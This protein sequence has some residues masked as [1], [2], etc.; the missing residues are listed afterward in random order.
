MA[1]KDKKSEVLTDEKK[2]QLLNDALKAIEKEYGKGSIMKL[3]DRSAVSV[4]EIPSCSLF[5]LV[6]VF[7]LY[8]FLWYLF[9]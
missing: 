3:G 4:D 6:N 9:F 2:D 5:F 7:Q 1:T 8:L